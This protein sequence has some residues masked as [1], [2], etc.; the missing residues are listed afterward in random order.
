MKNNCEN[1][2]VLFPVRVYDVSVRYK[3]LKSILA[4][5]TSRLTVE[6][7]L[8]H[9]A[10]HTL[11]FFILSEEPPLPPGKQTTWPHIS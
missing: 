6:K 3:C 7:N 2:L 9:T 4:S 11:I 5:F 8:G 10:F 1:A